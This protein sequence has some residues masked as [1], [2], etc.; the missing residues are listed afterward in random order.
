MSIAD[1]TALR[2]KPGMLDKATR[3]SFA[4]VAAANST[5]AVRIVREAPSEL[6]RL[7][8][9]PLETYS[10]AR[11][12]G[13]EGYAGD[14]IGHAAA[15]VIIGQTAENE[16]VRRGLGSITELLTHS[17]FPAA[18]GFYGEQSGRYAATTR[19]PSYWDIAVAQA[20]EAGDVPDLAQGAI[21]FLDPHNYAGSGTQNGRAL[22]PF[23]TRMQAW[24]LDE[25]NELCPDVAT[26]DPYFFLAMRRGGTPGSR[27]ADY[28]RACDIFTRGA[29][30]DHAPNEGDPDTSVWRFVGCIGLLAGLWLALRGGL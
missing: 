21:H 10:R 13:A 5:G 29:A 6:A 3:S 7:A 25:K 18:N 1:L 9:A 12:I 22:G 30:G 16:R 15:S 2:S 20:I 17:T 24:I 14:P 11:L 8:N 4:T 28:D 27:Q 26:I 23:A 19:D